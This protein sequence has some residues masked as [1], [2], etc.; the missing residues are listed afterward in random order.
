MAFNIPMCAAPRAP[1]PPNTKPTELPVNQRAS[2]EK[3]ECRFGSDIKT[4]AYKSFCKVN[5]TLSH[6]VNV[7]WEAGN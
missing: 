1:P 4:L 3:S 6:V 7:V 5:K 2:R